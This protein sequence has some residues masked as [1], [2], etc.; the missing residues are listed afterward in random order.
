[1][2]VARFLDFVNGGYKKETS[3]GPIPDE[4]LLSSIVDTT[5]EWAS[6][7]TVMAVIGVIGLIALVV[8]VLVALL[9]RCLGENDIDVYLQAAKTSPAGVAAAAAA[10]PTTKSKDD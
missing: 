6:E 7:N 4:T 2:C 8:A 10:A 3:T 5:V 1:M 9:D